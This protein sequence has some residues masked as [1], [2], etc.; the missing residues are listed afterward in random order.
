[1]PGIFVDGRVSEDYTAKASANH[2]IFTIPFEARTEEVEIVG[3]EIP[4]FGSSL[5][6]ILAAVMLVGITTVNMRYRRHSG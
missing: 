4:E 6:L 3:S 1:M 5:A 2:I